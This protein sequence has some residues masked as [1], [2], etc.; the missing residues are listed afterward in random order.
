MDR[1]SSL[2]D[3]IKALSERTIAN[4]CTEAEALTA[5]RLIAE[6]LAKYGLSHADLEIETT[7][8]TR[9]DGEIAECQVPEINYCACE[10]ANFF[11]CE[12]WL[13]DSEG[14][15]CFFGLPQDAFAAVTLACMIGE[16]M[17]R[18]WDNYRTYQRRLPL[19]WQKIPHH[20][21]RIR[22]AYMGA[23]GLRISQRLAAHK[24]ESTRRANALV[25]AKRELVKVGLE[26]AGIDLP[27]G[28]PLHFESDFHA[29]VAGS[30]A[31]SAVSLGNPNRVS[32]H[33]A[34]TRRSA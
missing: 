12:V 6:L 19:G 23:M 21:D 30:F 33:H 29:E 11:D 2:K 13:T 14:G 18:S 16:A 17:K 32:S 24:K 20:H 34:P 31:G 3:R 8:E 4:G 1:L 7:E 22:I 15:L 25:L 10:I 27:D 26:E 9:P 28:E 5:A